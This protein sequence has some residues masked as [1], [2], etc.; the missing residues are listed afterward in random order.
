MLS[1][2]QIAAPVL[3]SPR[4]GLSQGV[5]HGF[6]TREGGLTTGRNA[7]LSLVW[8]ADEPEAVARENW[9]R[10][11]RSLGLDAGSDR[12]V[13]LSQVHGDRVHEATAATGPFSVA[14]EYDGVVTD[15]AD[16]MLAVRAADCVPVLF[17]SPGTIGAAHAGWRG[18]AAGVV[19][20]TLEAL[21]RLD[22]LGPFEAV[23]GPHISAAAFEVGVEVVEGIAATG[24]PT[25][26]FVTMGPR[27]RPH[28]DLRAALVW[29]LDQLGVHAV[30]HV[31]GCTFADPRLYSH[32]REGH[33]AG[34][35]AGV[36]VRRGLR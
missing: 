11:G 18:V 20:R 4:F 7:S 27:G 31:E 35:G 12:V 26:H 33:G 21:R 15:R 32:R 22:P 24:V 2:A 5:D 30:F 9:D 14:G 8:R 36:I 34:R 19:P 17:A 16:L 6:T 25:S 10:V 29:Q 13:L 1:T 23:I 28:A 3:R